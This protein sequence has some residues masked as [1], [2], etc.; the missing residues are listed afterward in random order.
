[1]NDANFET[2]RQAMGLPENTKEIN[3]DISNQKYPLFIDLLHKPLLDMGLAFWWQ[4]GGAGVTMPGL[5]SLMWTRHLEYTGAN[6]SPETDHGLLP[7]GHGRRLAPL[8]HLLHGRPDG[9]LGVTARAD[10]GHDPRRQSIDALHEQPLLRCVHGQSTAGALPAMGP[11]QLVQPDHLV[12]WNVGPPAAVGIW[13]AG[14]RQLPEVRRP[15]HALLPYTYTCS[16]ITHDT[17]LPL[18][19]GMYLDYPDQEQAFASNQQFLFG[20]DLLVVPV[21]KPGNGKPVNTDVFCRPATIG[22]TIS[23]ATL[24]GRA[25]DRAR[26]PDR[27]H[28]LFARAG[29][30]IPTAPK[31]D[32]SDQKLVDPLTLDVYAGKRPSEFKLYEDDG[33][34]LDYRKGADAWTTIG[35]KPTDAAGNY[36]LTIGPADG[37]FAG[38]LPQRHYVVRVHGLLK[39]Q[40]VTVQ[41]TPLAEIDP[42]QCG[43]GWS[44]DPKTRTTTVRLPEA[45][46]IDQPVTVEL[47]QAGTAAYALVL[48][49]AINLRSQIR[50]AK[51]LL[52]L[53][54][55]ALLGGGDIKK[56]PRVMLKTEEVERELTA[57]V[58]HPQGAA[59]N[60]PDFQ[61]MRG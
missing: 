12:P 11:V 10:S 60:P 39:P 35:L 52:K 15:A 32:Y 19:R 23:R 22:S 33:T 28:A 46:A 9:H 2:I 49:K 16:R 34:S 27:S 53:K 38:Q 6:A 18:V 3:H 21:T 13:P 7:P 20:R 61:A 41:Q 29:S 45:Y 26:L 24:R 36:V 54:H 37:R 14:H 57:I 1:M 58:E 30:I 40:A 44:W 4:D 8:R 25:E 59:A 42:E 31:M 51:R 47:Q 48:Q 5:E 43:S 55:D 56:P 17:G 50:E